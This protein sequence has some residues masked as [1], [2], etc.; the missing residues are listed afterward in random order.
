MNHIR[1]IRCDKGLTQQY[2]A[3]KANV[4]RPFLVDLEKGRR[5]AKAD[6]KQRI[7]DA[8]GVT[9]DEAW[10]GDERATADHR[11]DG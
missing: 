3:E 10:G 7:A 8:L 4:S 5:G 11:A 6:T 1:E 2:V 9:V